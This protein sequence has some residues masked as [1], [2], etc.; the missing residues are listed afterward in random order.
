[1]EDWLAHLL[2]SKRQADELSQIQSNC[3][4]FGKATFFPHPKPFNIQTFVRPL[5]CDEIDILEDSAAVEVFW[6]VR[7]DYV[8]G[9][10]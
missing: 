1:V 5:C 9:R 7:D 3:N 2:S 6:P 10:V 4:P 8:S